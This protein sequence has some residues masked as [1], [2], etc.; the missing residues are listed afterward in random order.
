MIGYV[1]LLRGINLGKRSVK[2][3]ALR[4]L[5]EDMGYRDVRTLLASGNVVFFADAK[6]AKKLRRAIEAQFA[7]VF[8]FSSQIVLR[9][10]AEIAALIKTAPFK[11]VKPE[12]GVRMH[13]TFL[14]EGVKGKTKL[15]YT[16]PDGA[17]SVHAA[18]PG[19]LA[20]VVYP[21]TSSIDLMDF[22]GKEFG[23]DATMRTW[24]TV[25]KID[26]LLNGKK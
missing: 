20:C 17:Y 21:K 25:Q 10:A 1:A 26:E 15:P 24:N 14:N 22:L 5:F 11:K 8:G 19:H 9:N 4:K 13:I 12:E 23:E 2:M 16:N 7:E 3:D 6:D 18:T